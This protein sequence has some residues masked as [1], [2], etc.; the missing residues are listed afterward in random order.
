MSSVRS[1]VIIISVTTTTIYGTWL[2]PANSTLVG[3]RAISTPKA[4]PLYRRNEPQDL[5]PDCLEKPLNYLKPTKKYVPKILTL[6][7]FGINKCILKLQTYST[8]N[9]KET[10][11][12]T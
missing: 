4:W 3:Q 10:I 5:V 7:G 12:G 2:D 8:P 9:L 11:L 1:T 6:D